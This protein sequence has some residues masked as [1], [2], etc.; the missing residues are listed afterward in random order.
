MKCPPLLVAMSICT[1]QFAIAEEASLDLL[2]SM[3]LEELTML[4][5]EMGTATKSAQKLTDIPSSV[6]VLSNERI[7][8]SGVRTIAEALMLVPGLKVTKFSET[9]WFVSARGFH[10]GLYNKMLVMMDG[11]SLFSPVYGGTYWTNIDYILAD[12]ERIEVLKGPGGSI[13]GGNAVNGVVNI[14][15]KSAAETQG[16]YVSGLTLGSDDYELSVRQG[17]QLSETVSSRAFYK[18]KKEPRYN[19]EQSSIWQNESAGIVL[20]SSDDWVL[21]VGGNKTSYYQEWGYFTYDPNGIAVDYT[22]DNFDIESR[23]AYL[24][25]DSTLDLND[26]ASLSYSIWAQNNEDNAPDAPGEYTT[27]NLDSTVTY[28]AN[29]T[30]MITMGGGIRYMNLDFSSSQVDDI[31][32]E[33]EWYRRA[34]NIEKASDFILNAFVQS[35]YQ[36]TDQFSTTVGAK[37]EHFEQNASTELSPQIR[38]L[39]KLN[40]RHSTWFGVSRSVVSPSY[41]DTNS[42]FFTTYYDPTWGYYYWETVGD[43]NL[44]NENVATVEAGYRYNLGNNFELD[45]T[46]FYSQHSNVRAIDIDYDHSVSRLNDDYSVV[47]QGIEVGAKYSLLENLESYLSYSYLN[48]KG[49]KEPGAY[50]TEESAKFFDIDHEHIATLQILW[51]ITSTLQFDVLSK[52]HNVQYG[53]HNAYEAQYGNIDPNLSFDARLGWKKSSSAPL[54][55]VIVENIGEDEGYQTDWSTSKNVNQE[56]VYVRVSHEF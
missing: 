28:Q 7:Q 19:H 43:S 33:L 55:E 26:Q 49:S 34:Y 13:W 6:Y 5:I 50:S 24:Q 56:S 31:N 32:N 48:S 45:T 54:F 47:T 12:I 40:Q 36:W 51:N 22:E 23:S 42:S 20:E 53:E 2:M 21:K 37:V 10:D 15:T 16:T 14:I 1:S 8:R 25:F 30:H 41:M 38:A 3:S 46:A 9:E 4:D 18:H 27:I 44:E 17:V 29:D 39:Y 52:Y 11:R 35:Q